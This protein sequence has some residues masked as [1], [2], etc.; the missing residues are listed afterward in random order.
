LVIDYCNLFGYCILYLG[1]FQNMKKR[2]TK[3]FFIRSSVMICKDILGK[4]M[5]RKL[6]DGRIIS[7]KIV[8]VEAYIGPQD[9]ASHAYLPRRLRLRGKVKLTLRNRAEF[10]IGGHV[11][12]YLVYGMYWQLNITTGKADYPECFLIRAIELISP[13]SSLNPPNIRAAS[14]PG[15]LCNYFKLDKSFYGENVARSKKLWF[16]DR[17]ERMSH[18]DIVAT[19]RIGIDYAGPYWARRKLRFYIKNNSAISKI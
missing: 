9:R 12:I 14:G 17:G 11:Y 8:E 15:K 13:F 5:V 2:L 7:G 19:P 3:Q 4:Y 16:E 18:K 10:L 6:P 1:Y